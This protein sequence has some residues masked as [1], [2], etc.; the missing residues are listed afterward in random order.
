MA[1]GGVKQKAL[2]LGDYLMLL[3]YFCLSWLE[4]KYLRRH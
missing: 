1:S 4:Q 2:K 3:L